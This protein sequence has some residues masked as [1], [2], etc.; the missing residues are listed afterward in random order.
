[1]IGEAGGDLDRQLY[2]LGSNDG[3]QVGSATNNGTGNPNPTRALGGL[4]GATG[5]VV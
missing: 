5:P 3:W 1:L 2:A 4:P